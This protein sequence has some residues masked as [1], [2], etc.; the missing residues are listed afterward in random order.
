[1]K[2]LLPPRFFLL[3]MI[4]MIASHWIFDLRHFILYPFNI[5][6]LVLIIA[7]LLIAKYNSNVFEKAKINIITFDEPTILKKD[8]MYRYTR[9]PMYLGFTISL[10]GMAILLQGSISSFVFTALFFLVT[11]IW[12]IRYEEKMMRNKFLDEY[13]LYCKKVRRWI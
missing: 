1:M 7:G 12:Y 4:L 10:F 3:L 9:N 8:G 2:K 5:I 6:G 13:E 11:D